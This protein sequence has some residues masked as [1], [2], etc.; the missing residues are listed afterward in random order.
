[1]GNSVG[2]YELAFSAST[3]RV[4]SAL[5]EMAKRAEETGKLAERVT[6]I[7]PDTKGISDAIKKLQLMQTEQKE[8]G[9]KLEE[10]M[11]TGEKASIKEIR[12]LSAAK[13]VEISN[14]TKD[15]EV[16]KAK[17]NQKLDKITSISAKVQL[18]VAAVVGAGMLQASE[19]ADKAEKLMNLNKATGLTTKTL[20]ELQFVASQSGLEFEPL[21]KSVE[22][23][24]K[25]L[26]NEAIQQ[27]LQGMGIAV[28]D[29][30][31]KFRDM[32]AIFQDTIG[33]LGRMPEGIERNNIATQLFGKSS[34][35]MAPI[36][37]MGAQGFS[38]LAD[39]AHKSGAVMSGE[40]LTAAAAMDEKFDALNAKIAGVKMKFGELALSIADAAM[41]A[42]NLLID[43]V[44]PAI[45]VV[46]GLPKPLSGTILGF[47]GIVSVAGPAVKSM[48]A[49]KQA[50]DAVR[51]STLLAKAGINPWLL[52]G[53]IAAIAG[54]QM[55]VDSQLEK[56]NASDDDIPNGYM[57]SRS[58]L[59]KIK[60]SAENV[61]N[62]KDEPKSLP[63]YTMPDTSK[64]STAAAAI[65]AAPQGAA[66]LQASG[67][68][69]GNTELVAHVR[70]IKEAVLR[71]MRV[72]EGSRLPV[73]TA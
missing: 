34:A 21:M 67:S 68:L 73:V 24:Q 70:D 60:S 65:A 2:I 40:T 5:N 23:L 54:A 11:I 45:D 3:Q 35:E 20:Q 43:I 10:A 30:N 71:I 29:S 63:S 14:L 49:I 31:G 12:N 57:G 47:L 58:S 18:P 1:M 26:G 7:K 46:A 59:D 9:K 22:K 16:A 38:D 39:Q 27:Q 61:A 72:V 4:Q 64:L 6:S 56:D 28:K 37:A 55:W 48:K 44:K 32:N 62:S 8:L 50:I 25:N 33:A 66:A 52:A 15:L 17:Q 19:M 53:G 42:L 41:P 51:N 69:P 36:I 13:R